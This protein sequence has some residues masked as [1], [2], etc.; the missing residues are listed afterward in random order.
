MTLKST[1]Q[2]PK[3]YSS[4]SASA[5]ESR[6]DLTSSWLSLALGSSTS[7]QQQLLSIINSTAQLCKV[8]SQRNPQVACIP[9]NLARHY[10][11]GHW[12]PAFCTE[13]KHP[14]PEF[15]RYHLLPSCREPPSVLC[16]LR[17]APF[18]GTL[19]RCRRAAFVEGSGC[20]SLPTHSKRFHLQIR[21]KV[22]LSPRLL[23]KSN[24]KGS[25]A[26]VAFACKQSSKTL[27]QSLNL[28]QNVCVFWLKAKQH[29]GTKPS[30]GRLQLA[31]FN[32]RTAFHRWSCRNLPRLLLCTFSR[33]TGL[34][35]LS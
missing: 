8:T 17:A 32:R 15:C 24:T 20:W 10:Y 12:S 35:L 9:S 31:G 26:G 14:Q 30:L 18:S 11:Q 7:A 23:K 21:S 5:A 28:L 22:D 27:S 19:Q 13:Q 3:L 16:W 33:V 6:D 2:D 25:F 4:L 29:L 34:Q 1:A